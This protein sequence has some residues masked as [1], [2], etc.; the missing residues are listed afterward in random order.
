MQ[1]ALRAVRITQLSDKGIRCG[2]QERQTAGDY[3]KRQKK[4]SVAAG[5]RCGPEQKRPRSEKYKPDDKTRFVSGAAHEKCR[6]HGQQK[7]SHV[8]SGLHQ[9]RLEARYRERLHEMAAQKG[10]EI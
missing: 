4:K 8:K 9:T 1:A 2:L 10:A 3:E 7:I 5:Q 6:R